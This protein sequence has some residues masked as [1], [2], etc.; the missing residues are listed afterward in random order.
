MVFSRTFLV[1]L[2]QSVAV[3]FLLAPAAG[4]QQIASL[5]HDTVQ[6]NNNSLVQ[7]D[8]D[9]FALAYQGSGQDG[10][11]QTFTIPA[12]GSS[13]TEV[14]SVVYE[15]GV[16]WGNSFVRV[17]ADTFALAYSDGA[18]DGWIRTFTISSDGASITEA[19]S[20]EFDAEQGNS[21]SLAQVDADTY[22]LAY[23]GVD[24]DGFIKTFSISP[25][26]GLVVEVNWQEHDT[27]YGS[28]NSLVHVD[29]DV[30]AL[31][32]AG[33]GLDGFIKTFTISA[34][35]V[36]ITEKDVVEHDTSRGFSNSLVRIDADTVALA[37][38]S[39]GDPGWLKTFTISP[40]DQSITQVDALEFDPVRGRNESLVHVDGETYA[41]AYSGE[42]I[43]GYVK[44]F[45]IPADG[46]SITEGIGLEHDP[47][48]GLDSSLV[49][50]AGGI[51][52]LAYEGDG[53]DGFIKTFDLS[54][55]FLDGFESGD[56]T[57]W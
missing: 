35:G 2:A 6:G 33:L 47:L 24:N 25:D 7:V 50:V 45:A 14:H 52:A 10:I 23:A 49:H 39:D 40:A 11:I 27:S 8:A 55:L 34:D 4:A 16:A 32:Y 57:G 51:C 37:Y 48:Y 46:S 26:T 41:L 15:S 21:C 9:T 54:A 22:V 53:N 30:F 18:D 3:V 5:E 38:S 1:A 44:T 19:D 12:D 28:Y 29:G 13:I 43:H 56:T 17:D 31:A 42:D 36:T 20:L